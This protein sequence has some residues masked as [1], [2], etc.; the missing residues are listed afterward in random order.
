MD[1]V[2][3]GY[4]RVIAERYVGSVEGQPA[5]RKR[6]LNWVRIQFVQFSEGWST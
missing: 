1:R 3:N 6:E 4:V 5:S 2:T